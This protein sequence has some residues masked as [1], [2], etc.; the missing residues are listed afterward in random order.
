MSPRIG[1]LR[2][3]QISAGS[4][5]GG[6]PSTGPVTITDVTGT[7]SNGNT[8]TVT[9][10]SLTNEQSSVWDPWFTTSRSGFE[11]GAAG[12]AITADGYQLPGGS[13]GV[14]DSTTFLM[15]TKAARFNCAGTSTGSPAN[16]L[17]DYNNTPFLSTNLQRA[18]Y[19]RG[20]YQ[21]LVPGGMWPTGHIK[22]F[23][24]NGGFYMQPNANASRAMPTNV[25]AV[26]QG[27]ATKFGGWP[28]GG[29]L[30]AGRWYCME[31]YVNNS[32]NTPTFTAWVDGTQVITSSA[33]T[34]STGV[35]LILFGI[36]NMNGSTTGF[37]LVA[38]S[39]GFTASSQRVY[40]SVVVELG[41]SSD[42]SAASKIY[43]AP[44]RISDTQVQ[45]V[46]NSTGITSSGSTAGLTGTA[47]WVFVTNNAQQQS[48]GHQVVA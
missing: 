34:V 38:Y 5:G 45:F 42:Y 37:D 20:Y 44:T 19:V 11:G 15:G 25:I 12:A 43:Q 10:A 40:P 29:A 41:D 7:F 17:T 47:R 28:H 46:Y 32:S 27:Q 2:Y 3:R 33:A 22:M 31:C 26:V 8:I 14:Y 18:M 24:I 16:N 39:D 1:R 13:G 23:E 6:A 21:W 36:P 9:G 4:T 35:N 48:S 30:V